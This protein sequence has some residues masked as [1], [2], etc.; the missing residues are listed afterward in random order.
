[1]K[2]LFLLAAVLFA[3]AAPAQ[4]QGLIG[5]PSCCHSGR[6]EAIESQYEQLR[7]LLRAVTTA[8]ALAS[9]AFLLKSSAKRALKGA[10]VGASVNCGNTGIALLI[11]FGAPIIT[12][13]VGVFLINH[14]LFDR[15]V[16]PAQQQ[17]FAVAFD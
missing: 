7:L 11:F 10:M 2:K 16:L 12:H 1:M 3:L 4:A 17:H 5:A 9:T 15:L 8:V 13:L 14:Y 6:G